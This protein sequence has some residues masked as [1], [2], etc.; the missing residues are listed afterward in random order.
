MIRDVHPG[1]RIRI[2]IFTHPGSRGQ[3]VTDP[4]SA[5]LKNINY[6]IFFTFSLFENVLRG[7]KLN[8]ICNRNLENSQKKELSIFVNTIP[9]VTHPNCR[10]WCLYLLTCI[11]TISFSTLDTLHLCFHSP[12]NHINPNSHLLYPLPTHLFLFIIG[13]IAH[14]AAYLK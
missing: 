14:V 1:S 3:K 8:S 13:R 6:F 9:D 5:T 7:K 4:G 2:F 12:P 11:H 10:N